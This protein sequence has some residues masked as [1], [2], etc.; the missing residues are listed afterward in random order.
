MFPGFSQELNTEQLNELNELANSRM[1]ADA[2]ALMRSK[3]WQAMDDDERVDALDKV[4]SGARRSAKHAF[5]PYLRNGSR[6]AINLHR[7][8]TA[9]KARSKK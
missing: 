4:M 1:H 5:T 2:S 6:G 7:Q 8:Q 3:A 9:A